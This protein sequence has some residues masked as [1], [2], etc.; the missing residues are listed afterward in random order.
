MKRLA[1]AAAAVMALGM[2]AARAA[3]LNPACRTPGQPVSEQGFVQIGGIRQWVT[4]DGQ[5]CANPVVLIV[6]GGPG[7][8]NTPFAHNLF[9]AW[10]KDF[11][12]VQ[13]DQRGAGKTYG[14]NRPA[15]DEPLTMARLTQDGVEAARYAL[16]RLGKRQ[17]IL[18]GGSWGS[19]LAVNI[20]MA[21]PDLFS[22]YVGTAQ[23]ANY[24]ADMATSYAKTL[25]LA[26]AAGDTDALAKLEPLGPPPWTNPR[27]FGIL[28]RITRKYEAQG[29]E[30]PPKDWFAFGPGYDTPAYEADYTAGEDYSFLNFVGLHGDGMGP[31]IDLRQLGTR[32]AMPV[33]ML[34]GEADLVT[35][36]EVSKPYFDA[37]VAPKKTWVPLPR[38][39]H[40]P[41]RIMVDAQLAALKAAAG[42]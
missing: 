16:Q 39:G 10:A 22:A 11:T 26:K 41:N 37:I 13:W 25:A 3:E 38:T 34:Q 8:P 31:K 17:V 28:R 29:S 40:D 24:Q 7:N 12:V 4:V 5:D 42:R 23:L 18:M 20:A 1:M 14:E 15:E 6:H 30:A 19:A 27:A 36:P 21:Q 33:W 35:P 9:G 32:F 2:G